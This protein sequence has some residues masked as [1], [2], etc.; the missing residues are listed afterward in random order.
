ML[1]YFISREPIQVLLDVF[2]EISV[3]CQGITLEQ[4]VALDHHMQ[5]FYDEYNVQTTTLF[6]Q[7]Q[8]NTTCAL[9]VIGIS[10]T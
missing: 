2:D 5:S 8:I 6:L 10:K 4:Y 3:A 9:C 1:C 7:M